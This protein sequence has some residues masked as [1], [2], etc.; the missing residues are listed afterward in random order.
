MA[1]LLVLSHANESR[2]PSTRGHSAR[3]TAF[4][5]AVAHRL[6]CW[7]RVLEAIRVGGPL[8]DIGKLGIPDEV[9]LKPGPLD[10][11]EQDVVRGHP[12][13]GATL[14]RSVAGLEVAVGCVL[15]HHERWDGGG[16]PA[17]LAGEAIPLEARVLAVADAFD[18]MI[19]TRPY[20]RA[21]AQSDA[22]AELERCSGSQFDPFVAEAFAEAWRERGLDADTPSRGVRAAAS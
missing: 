1:S 4:A 21:M 17:G 18:A 2:D 8:H 19:S 15:H 22:V 14:V 5:L 13:A 9:L 11:E 7:T 20:R 16:Y 10:D 12:V 6:G 3:V